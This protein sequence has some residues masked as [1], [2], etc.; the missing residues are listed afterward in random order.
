MNEGSPK[1]ILTEFLSSFPTFSIE[2]VSASGKLPLIYFFEIHDVSK[3]KVIIKIKGFILLFLNPQKKKLDNIYNKIAE[4]S[5]DSFYLKKD[6]IKDIEIYREFFQLNLIIILW[7]M[8]F[9]KI[10]NK[11][12]NYLINKLIKDFEGMVIELGGSETSFRKKI[13]ILVENFYG[14][15]YIYSD[16]FDNVKTINDQKLSSIIFKNFNQK[17]DTKMIYKYIKYH[18]PNFKKMDI[19]DFW[20]LNFFKK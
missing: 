2:S 3:V 4:Q 10:N 5:K 11:Y 12:T 17:I 9:K 1:I 7:Y 14:R 19:N 15:L 8:R 13:R 16:L 18:I 6:Q 20:E